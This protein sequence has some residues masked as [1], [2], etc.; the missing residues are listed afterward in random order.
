MKTILPLIVGLM[1]AGCGSGKTTDS[2]AAF[3]RGILRL[4]Q[5]LNE[6]FSGEDV[7]AFTYDAKKSDSLLEPVV[8]EVTFTGKNKRG[9]SFTD[10]DLR[11]AW[12]DNSW[13]IRSFNYVMSSTDPV[14][15]G[16]PISASYDPDD[17][18]WNRG[19]VEAV[20]Y[21]TNLN[22]TGRTA[23]TLQVNRESA[24]SLSLDTNVAR[25][26]ESILSKPTIFH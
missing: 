19:V 13:A 1:L 24:L 6:L 15:A 5:H 4:R 3:E 16:T 26:A 22:E 7:F 14:L 23:V 20:R 25:A 21:D 10:Y 17:L 11:L 12:H 2:A 9:G 8:G 18:T